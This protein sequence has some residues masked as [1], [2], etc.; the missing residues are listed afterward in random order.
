MPSQIT[1]E[2]IP[3]A[4]RKMVQYTTQNPERGKEEPTNS[5]DDQSILQDKIRVAARQQKL[6][7][8]NGPSRKTLGFDVKLPHNVFRKKKLCLLERSSQTPDLYL[9]EMMSNDLKRAF[10]PEILH[11]CLS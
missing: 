7:K 1:P 11:M 3:N 9:I 8:K 6:G 10:P 5:K 4:I 2:T